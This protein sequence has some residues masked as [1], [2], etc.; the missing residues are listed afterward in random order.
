[1]FYQR[2]KAAQLLVAI[3]RVSSTFSSEL[4]EMAQLIIDILSG[5]FRVNQSPPLA[6]WHSIFFRNHN[7]ICELIAAQNPSWNDERL[8]KECRRINIAIYQHIL[9]NEYLPLLLSK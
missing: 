3:E 1:M 5:D 2:M 8:F 6:Q 7:R 4:F 9:F